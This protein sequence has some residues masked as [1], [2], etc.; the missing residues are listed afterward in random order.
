MIIKIFVS[1]AIIGVLFLTIDIRELA[2]LLKGIHI[3][4]LLIIIPLVPV[5]IFFRA[6]R[7]HYLI[8][9]GQERKVS[10]LFSMKVTLVGVALNIFLPAQS[11]EVL[12]GYF[13][14]KWSGIR[15]RMFIIS[16]YDK[17]IAIF[18]IGFLGLIPSF[19]YSNIWYFLGSLAAFA[20]LIVFIALIKIGKTKDKWL[21][22]ANKFIKNKIDF[23]LASEQINNTKT[24]LFNT[25]LLSFIGWLLTYTIF[26]LCFR[27]L[28]P[29]ISGPPS[30]F[31]VF[32]LAPVLTLARLF[33]FTLNGLGTDE[34]LIVFLFGAQGI[35]PEVSFGAA[36]IYKF[37][38][39]IVPGIAGLFVILAS[40]NKPRTFEPKD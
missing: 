29:D 18:S 4:Y 15:E 40:L 28:I 34:A 37:I 17:L 10:L 32:M 35:A 8:N 22:W 9:Q 30:L 33:P 7:W 12:K 13:G 21:D 6:W 2:A 26:W 1:L 27:L 25:L 24:T 5:S 39:I 3:N 14:Y 23:R 16:L 36:L 20:P 31:F 38:L 19:Y 11:G